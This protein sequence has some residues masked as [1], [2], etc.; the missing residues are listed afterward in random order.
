MSNEKKKTAPKKVRQR[1]TA[2]EQVDAGHEYDRET[3]RKEA[4]KLRRPR[5]YRDRKKKES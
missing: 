1:E 5:T 4:A 3:R 2:R